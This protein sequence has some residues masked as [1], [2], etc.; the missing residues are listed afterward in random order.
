VLKRLTR[1]GLRKGML[2]G[3]RPWL[4]V[5]VAA[6]GLRLLG[7]IMRKDP[8]ILYCSEISPGQAIVVSLSDDDERPEVQVSA[9]G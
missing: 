6:G 1:T 2:G 7:R 4:F 3:S 8:E 5:G 9:E